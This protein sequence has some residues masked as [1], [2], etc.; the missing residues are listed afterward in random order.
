MSNAIYKKD[1]HDVALA[2]AQGSKNYTDKVAEEILWRIGDYDITT[3]TDNTTASTK[4]VPS[5]AT[6]CKIKRIYGLCIF[7]RREKVYGNCI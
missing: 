6:R 4:L 2:V 3:Q 1:L 5:G 7:L